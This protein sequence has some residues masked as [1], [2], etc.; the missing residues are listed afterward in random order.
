MQVAEPMWNDP[1]TATIQI[2][3]PGEAL[4][5]ETF[6]TNVCDLSGLGRW[7]RCEDMALFLETARQLDSGLFC[8]L[9]PSRTWE[10][11]SKAGGWAVE[12]GVK[13][14]R[15]KLIIESYLIMSE[16]WRGWE[17]KPTPAWEPGTRTKIPKEKTGTATGSSGDRA[18]TNGQHWIYHFLRSLGLG[19]RWVLLN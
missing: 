1:Q 17:E 6:Y 4:S 14:K 13:E 9:N 5:S 16:T 12:V 10:G 11:L 15:M 8:S 2:V 18:N 3:C 19:A 7:K